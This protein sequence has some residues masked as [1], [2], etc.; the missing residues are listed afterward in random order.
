MPSWELFEQQSIE[1]QEKVLPP[2][3]K[4]RVAIEAGISFGWKRWVGDSGTIIGLDCFGASAP[5]AVLFN[6]FGFTAENIATVTMDVMQRFI[7]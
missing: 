1:Y 7:T 2:E 4:A 3:I 5:E 6:T